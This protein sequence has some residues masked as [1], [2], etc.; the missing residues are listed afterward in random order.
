MKPRDSALRLKRFEAGEKARKVSSLETMILDLEH[1][2]TDLARQI[3][4]E[5]E[6]TGIKDPAHF[7]YSTFAKAA[8]QRRANLLTSIA[9]LKAKLD[10][11]RREHEE[12]A[13]ELSKLEPVEPRD[14]DRQHGKMSGNGLMLG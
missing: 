2:A 13:L 6:R 4:V 7:A 11:A 14:A 3:A 10:S 5:E 12:I 9:D 8:S 1:I